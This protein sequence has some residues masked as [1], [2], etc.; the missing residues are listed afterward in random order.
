MAQAGRL[1]RFER[2]RSLL[3]RRRRLRARPV[4]P[5]PDGLDLLR[6]RRDSDRFVARVLCGP[7]DLG[8]RLQASTLIDPVATR[9]TPA[10]AP[11]AAATTGSAGRLTSIRVPLPMS[12]DTDS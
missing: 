7:A 8:H 10:S 9:A 3:E 4:V 2:A 11:D 12:D 5:K 6:R 1:C